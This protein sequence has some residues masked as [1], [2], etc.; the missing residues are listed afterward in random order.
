M[1]LLSLEDIY[2]WGYLKSSEKKYSRFEK[3]QSDH[4]VRQTIIFFSFEESF[5]TMTNHSLFYNF[6]I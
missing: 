4:I 6:G 2:S 5:T 1:H 3:V